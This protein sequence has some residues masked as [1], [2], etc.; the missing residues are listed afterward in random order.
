MLK[1]AT[2]THL[3]PNPAQPI[4]GIFVKHRIKA[5][6]NYLYVEVIAPVGWLP[7]GLSGRPRSVP[8]VRMDEG[9]LIHHPRFF[10]P[11][12]LKP[13]E[14]FFF[15][16]GT[17]STFIRRHLNLRFNVLDTH[18]AYPDAPAVWILASIVHRPFVVTVR[19]EDVYGHPHFPLRKFQIVKTLKFASKVICL[20]DVTYKCC[21]DLNIQPSKIIKIPNGVDGKIFKL[22]DRQIAR[23]CLGIDKDVILLLSVGWLIPRKGYHYVIQALPYLQKI[24]PNIQYVIIGGD[25]TTGEYKKFLITLSEKLKVKHLVSFIDILPQ[26]KLSLWMNAADVFCLPS[27]KE[28]WGNVALEALSCGTPVVAHNVGGINQ[29]IINGVNGFILEDKSPITW[30][31]VLNECFNRKWNRNEIR[32]SVSYWQWDNVGKQ[33]A[34]LMEQ[35]WNEFKSKC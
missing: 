19:G 9:I 12:I 16:Q 7:A 1:I 21:I 28:G 25:T 22:I 30:F 4:L 34:E 11:P 3:F 2:I 8:R 15:L 27:E 5:M 13:L 10:S 20:S 32:S 33:V 17:I 6:S 18:F 29:M 26:D 31:K 23:Q 24:H 14:S 35:V